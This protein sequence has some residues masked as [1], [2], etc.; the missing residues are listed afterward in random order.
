MKSANFK[1]DSMLAKHRI[2]AVQ[3]QPQRVRA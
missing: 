2:G 1:S 3:P